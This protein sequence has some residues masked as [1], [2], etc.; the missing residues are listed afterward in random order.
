EQ[1]PFGQF[2]QFPDRLL[3][4]L[5][6]CLAALTGGLGV[7]AGRLPF[8]WARAGAVL[9]VVT[10]LVYGAAARLQPQ[11]LALP[12]SLGPREA[13]EYEQLSGAIGTTAKG[14]FTPR[15]MGTAP[16][17]SAN[18]PPVPVDRQLTAPAAGP[19]ELPV[20]YY[21][22]WTATIDG[23]PAAVQP[24]SRGL[25]QVEAPAPGAKVSLH[26]GDTPDRRLADG[27]AVAGLLLL[28]ALGGVPATIRRRLQAPHSAAKWPV[29]PPATDPATGAT[30]AQG[31][32]PDIAMASD[33]LPLTSDE[34]RLA[35]GGS[36]LDARLGGA[37]SVLAHRTSTEG[38]HK[39][40]L[41][42][43]YS[44][45]GHEPE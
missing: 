5:G 18:V 30:P 23:A 9:L 3:V 44:G 7:A 38:A 28:A 21:P 1:L 14:E 42:A 27:L 26:F 41:A 40:G 17:A 24:G 35:R 37:R 31:L 32:P 34:P 45:S 11:Y 33:T 39:S 29:W 15:W 13:L 6:F 43:L 12:A 36:G 10:A 25:I 22:G 8:W 4:V 19:V 20:A 16:L 2:L